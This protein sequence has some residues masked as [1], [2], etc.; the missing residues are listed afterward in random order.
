MSPLLKSANWFQRV[1]KLSSN[2]SSTSSSKSLSLGDSLSDAMVP[3]PP[4]TPIPCT[5]TPAPSLDV[6]NIEGAP[7]SPTSPNELNDQEKN[8]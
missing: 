7:H 1:P 2:S 8:R 6:P 3:P 5:P 4:P